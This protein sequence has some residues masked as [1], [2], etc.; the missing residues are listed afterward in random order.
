MLSVRIGFEKKV[1]WLSLEAV[2]LVMVIVLGMLA[3]RNAEG[4]IPVPA[5][6]GP[7]VKT[8][9]A[10]VML[11]GNWPDSKGLGL[12]KVGMGNG[13]WVSAPRQDDCQVWYHQP[14]TRT[15]SGTGKVRVGR[16][17]PARHDRGD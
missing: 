12:S 7:V 16:R 14:P 9:V 17:P 11:C 2:V 10:A 1:G 3:G 15:K 8:G 4:T 5:D 6:I 13:M